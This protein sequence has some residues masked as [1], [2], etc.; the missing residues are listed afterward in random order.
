R[1]MVAVRNEL[2]QRS[3]DIE[4]QK[5]EIEEARQAAEEARRAAEEQRAAA[6]SANQA[7]SAFLANMSHELRTPLNAII[8]Y[9]ELLQEE[10]QDSGYDSLIADLQKICS[11]GKHLLRL[12]N[13][14]LDL[15]KIEA[16]KM[17]LFVETFDVTELVEDVAVTAEPLVQK[18]GNKFV[19]TM[20]PALGSLKGDVTKLKQ[21]LLNL[22][23]NASKFTT[24]GTITLD[25][26][27][28]SDMDGNWIGFRVSDTG[29]GMNPEVL[30][31]L[32]QA[33][34][35]ADASTTR[36]YGG[37]GL[38]LAISKTLV[39]LMQGRIW[40]ES[41]AGKG[42]TFH[43]HAR[44][45]LQSEPMPRRMFRADEL[46]GVRVLVVDDN[47]SAREILSA[48]ARNFG[49]EVDTAQDGQQALNMIVEAEKKQLPYD[50]VLM[51]W[52]MPAMDGVET[53]QHLQDEHLNKLP[54]IIMVT[55]YGREEALGSA[56]QRGVQLK[57]VLTKPVN[58]STLLEA[59]G[60]VLGKGI[61]VE[62]RASEKADDHAEVMAQLNGARL[63][64]V[65]DNDMNQEL[66]RELL[67]QAGISVVIANNGQESLD[68]LAK[69]A[70]FDGVLMDCQMPV[71]DGYTATREIRKN[72]AFQELPIIAMTAN[73]MTGDREK[74][75][76][77]G[78]WDHIAKP[79]NVTEMY[80]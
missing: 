60:E 46:L 57:T 56:E 15:S 1:R 42:S 54:S 70:A 64:L 74:V 48:M 80:A 10:A 72:P 66:A 25:V 21:I 62:S 36:K 55:A 75:I 52:K 9:S 39:E 71:M 37:T 77:A 67:E 35:Q 45:G 41:E 59:I 78:M 3:L 5:K 17:D 24:K 65:E 33:F 12:I 8:G 38:G 22:L 13:S 58:S 40:V 18:N 20:Q 61:D 30:A 49:L 26:L 29:V 47:A 44:F 79:L 27:R 63:L 68:I 76:E 16:G 43:F 11:S 28:E 14:V 50:L 31:K 2:Q 34:T 32:F 7:K 51:D 73:A 23:S 53:V 6:D 69:D 19:L 4:R